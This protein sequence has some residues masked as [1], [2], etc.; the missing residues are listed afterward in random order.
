MILANTLLLLACTGQDSASLTH[1]PF[2]G[3]SGPDHAL[4]WARARSEGEYV[5]AL[6][7]GGERR[8]VSARAEGTRDMTLCWRVDGLSPGQAY[9]FEVLSGD[10]VIHADGVLRAGPP[11]DAPRVRL[12]FASC[13]NDRRFPRQAGW[14]RMLEEGAEALFLLGDTPYID[15]TELEV[16]RRRY[17]EFYGMPDVAAALSA[18]PFHAT[19][20]D[21]DFGQNDTDGRLS[22]KERSRQA[23]VE[24][25]A[26]PSA[27]EEGA[28][29]YCRVRRG[30]IEVFL[31]D[32][33]TFGGTEPSPADPE[34]QTLLGAAQWSW[35]LRSLLDSDAPFK[36]LATGMIW[37]GA[38]RPGKR[39][40]WMTYPHER[41][42]LF[43]F[44]GEENIS[45][46]VLLGGDIH[47]SRALR[48]PTEDSVGYPLTELITSPLANT[49]IEAANAPS[50][51]L[52]HDVG[53]QESFLLLEADMEADPPQ[54]TG[55]CLG[56]DGV[57]HFRVELLLPQLRRG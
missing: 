38:T 16:Q 33:R 57:E 13:A 20:D 28:G 52:L 34:R 53:V 1:G 45:G 11:E 39:D 8:T 10:E 49:V 25:H 29:I 5:L 2:L 36:V 50:P 18:V 24:Y 7:A 15:S 17:R 4:V 51:Y 3:S 21:H 6:E 26:N 31:L 56:A 9:D 27:G 22:G 46:V 14:A 48:Y 44:L 47:R 35:L 54:L 30:P 41:S 55:R 40:H 43:E 42:A 37:N 23:F 12:G 19:W 32:A